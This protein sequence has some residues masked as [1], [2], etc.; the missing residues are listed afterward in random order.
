M[1]K[2]LSVLAVVLLALI[3]AVT[4]YMALR[5]EQFH[6]DQ[7]KQLHK[8][9]KSISASGDSCSGFGCGPNPFGN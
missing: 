3:L 7:H 2:T 4:V 1:T 9:G 6:E 5:Q 8:I